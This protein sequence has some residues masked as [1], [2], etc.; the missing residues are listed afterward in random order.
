VIGSAEE[1]FR[2]LPGGSALDARWGFLREL[3][4]FGRG[5]AERWFD[6][7][8]AGVGVRPT[9]NL[10]TFAAPAVELRLEG[11]RPPPATPRTAPR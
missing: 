1:A 4:D 2:A 10:A 11:G 3:R 7:N 8:L 9:P 6:E 5:A